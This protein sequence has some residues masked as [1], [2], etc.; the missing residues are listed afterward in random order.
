MPAK[1]GLVTVKCILPHF[2][3]SIFLFCKLSPSVQRHAHVCV[4]KFIYIHD[5]YPL[6]PGEQ[7]YCYEDNTLL[8][9][10]AE[11]TSEWRFLSV[12]HKLS[13]GLWQN[14]SQERHWRLF[15]N[16]SKIYF[17][18]EDTDR[19][20]SLHWSSHLKPLICSWFYSLFFVIWYFFP[21]LYCLKSYFLNLYPIP[22]PLLF[23]PISLYISLRDLHSS[24]PNLFIRL[25]IISV[26]SCFCLFY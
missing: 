7:S 2:Y 21:S 9:E 18:S 20:K 12:H 23:P 6:Y 15:I 19:H 3:C 4:S 8:Q 24:N 5:S 11:C 22:P 13:A 1:N 14:P 16:M 25:K 10:S 26:V 17:L